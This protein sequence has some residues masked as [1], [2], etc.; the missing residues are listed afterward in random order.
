M[1]WIQVGSFE[2]IIIISFVNN[3]F[4]TAKVKVM[5]VSVKFARQF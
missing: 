3:N 5:K 2:L 1:G 4:I